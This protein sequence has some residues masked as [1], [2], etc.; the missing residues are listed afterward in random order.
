MLEFRSNFAFIGQS[1]VEVRHMSHVNPKMKK[2][3]DS[4][5]PELQKAVLDKGIPIDSLQDLIFVL[6]Q[7][8]GQS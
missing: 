5:S 7:I 6:E 8:A 2:H 4:L 3:I 1:M